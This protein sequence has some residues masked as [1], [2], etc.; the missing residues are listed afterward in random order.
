[1]IKNVKKI[2]KSAILYL[3]L[4]IFMILAVSMKVNYYIDEIY[5]YGLSNYNGN[6]INMEIEYDKTYTPGTAVY[7]DYMKVQNGQRFDYVNVWRNQ[8]NDVHPPLYYALIHTICSVFPNKFSK[9]FAAGINIIFVL[10]TLYMVRKIISLFT[11]NKFI[12]WS[13]SLSFVTLSGIIMTATYFRM[14]CMA[15]F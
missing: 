1:M 14:Y 7:D 15:T 4:A 13:I 9:W 5:T 8:T 10:L 12:L 6:G 2:P 11:D 3:I